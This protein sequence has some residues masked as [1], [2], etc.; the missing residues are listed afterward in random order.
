L[1]DSLCD[2]ARPTTD[3][4]L[5]KTRT[6]VMKTILSQYHGLN[7]NNSNNV[8]GSAAGVFRAGSVELARTCVQ[9]AYLGNCGGVFL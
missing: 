7:I 6:S 5:N 8:T 2:V 3:K 9:K 1:I 4:L